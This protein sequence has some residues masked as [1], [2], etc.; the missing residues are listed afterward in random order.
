MTHNPKNKSGATGKV[1]IFL[2][3]IRSL[4]KKYPVPSTYPYITR[5]QMMIPRRISPPHTHT[6]PESKMLKSEKYLSAVSSQKIAFV[7]SQRGNRIGDTRIAP[8]SRY[9]LSYI[10]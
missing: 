2:P 1:F 7:M 10:A 9:R 3:V 6:G 5:A 4:V 8:I